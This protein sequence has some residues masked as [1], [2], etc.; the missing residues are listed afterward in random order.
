MKGQVEG[1][2]GKDIPSF[3]FTLIRAGVRHL[4]QS[5]N[6]QTE[7]AEACMMKLFPARL[8]S[9]SCVCERLE[10]P[11]ESI[12]LLVSFIND[13]FLCPQP[14]KSINK[15]AAVKICMVPSS[16]SRKGART[17][18]KERLV[19]SQIQEYT[20]L[21]SRITALWLALGR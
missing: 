3:S 21:K 15:R 6:S 17:L 16:P 2:Q 20:P 19:T 7:G 13:G 1:F 5:F 9:V 14:T 8:S 4:H 12:R 10:K 18:S 11:Q